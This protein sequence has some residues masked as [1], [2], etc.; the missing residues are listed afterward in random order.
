[1]FCRLK[2]N[3]NNGTGSFSSDFLLA[4]YLIPL[5]VFSVSFFRFLFIYFIWTF[6]KN[7]Q[8]EALWEL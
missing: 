8:K 3:G 5:F 4:Q 1:M 7:K 2:G 6:L